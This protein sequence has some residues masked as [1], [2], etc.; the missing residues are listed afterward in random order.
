VHALEVFGQLT[1]HIV[2]FN[3]QFNLLARKC[4]QESAPVNFLRHITRRLSPCEYITPFS[5]L[6]TDF[7]PSRCCP[8]QDWCPFPC[9]PES[10]WLLH[11][12]LTEWIRHGRWC[13]KQHYRL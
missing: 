8:G 11:R 2:F 5:A 6:L 12:G 1:S 13:F 7:P 4:H 9:V 10:R 3:D